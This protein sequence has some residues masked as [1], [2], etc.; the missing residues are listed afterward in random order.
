MA[1]E[2]E[3]LDGQLPAPD[4]QHAVVDRPADIVAVRRSARIEHCRRQQDVFPR[5]CEDTATERGYSSLG[6]YYV[7]KGESPGGN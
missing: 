3:R 1:D 5:D 4:D 6:D 7:G 2:I